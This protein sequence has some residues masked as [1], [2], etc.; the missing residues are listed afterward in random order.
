MGRK[1]K[2]I[3]AKGVTQEAIR[4]FLKLYKQLRV[5]LGIQAKDTQNIDE[6]RKA[7]GVYVN[8]RVLASSQKKKAYYQSLENREQALI[9]KCVLVIVKK[10]RPIVIFKG[11]NLQSTQFLLIVL[12]QLYVTLE[13]SQTLN[14][15]GAKQL[16]RVF[17]PKTK[18]I[19]N[20]QR[21]LILDS[22][23]SYVNLEFLQIYKQNKV[24]LLF[25]PTH[26]LYVLQPLDLL[27]FL[28]VKRF[29]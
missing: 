14:A 29:Y 13:N 18:P 20:Y 28:V 9:I 25:L 21:M 5:K 1:I 27:V 17:L 4:K 3:R 23:G 24:R 7:L 6:T 11:K 12:D 8:T 22:Y 2:A 19:A 10:L 16:E 15:I 26:S